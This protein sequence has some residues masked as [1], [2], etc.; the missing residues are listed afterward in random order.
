MGGELSVGSIVQTSTGSSYVLG[1]MSANATRRDGRNKRVRAA[2]AIHSIQKADEGGELSRQLATHGLAFSC[3]GADTG[4]R[5][6]SKLLEASFA[7]GVDSSVVGLTGH[8][9][10]AER[11]VLS[12]GDGQVVAAA[13][14]KLHSEH[15]T[16]ELPIFAAAKACRRQGYGSV[17]AALLAEIGRRLGVSVLVASATD[18]SR[19]FWVRQGFHASS[20]CPAQVKSAMRHLDQAGLLRG[21]ANS[22]LLARAIGPCNRSNDH[23]R[24]SF[25]AD[26]ALE[27]ALDRCSTER[28]AGLT[29]RR[30]A[31]AL[32]FKDI[33]S[34]GS[35][36]IDP[37]SGTSTPLV[38]KPHEELP[39][40]FRWVPYASLEAYYAGAD[41]GWGLRC[42]RAIS[43][44]QFV[45]EVLGRCLGEDE[46]SQLVDQSYAVG[47][48]D[49]VI[50][51]KR[52]VSDNNRSLVSRSIP[53]C[54][55]AY[56]AP[57]CLPHPTSCL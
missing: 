31:A 26:E 2:G 50:E 34:S 35:F 46:Y 51:A 17:L 57:C 33:H 32:G 29:A 47:F 37:V 18:E 48:P 44:D 27:G 43:Q 23:E 42:T 11:I 8:Y 16:I 15:S 45:C 36:W 39:E 5:E 53:S 30:A 55:L 20:F 38:R 28:V 13:V 7:S 24:Q 49:N 12:R 21:F 1:D 22:T 54:C 4:G 40:A 14:V 10:Q 6:A 41:R 56:S 25:T 9:R 19:G 52:K 3:G